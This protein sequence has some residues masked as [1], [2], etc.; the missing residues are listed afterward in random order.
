M[1]PPDPRVVR[2]LGDD[3]P[4]G[5]DKTDEPPIGLSAAQVRAALE[6]CA[7][8]RRKR[9]VGEVAEI[10]RTGYQAEGWPEPLG[11]DA[12]ALPDREGYLLLA[13]DGI[14]HTL[15]RDPFWAGYCSV[16]VNVNDICAMGGRPL[17]MVNVLIG[18]DEA[19]R[20]RIAEGI[21][22]GSRHFQVPMVGGH[23]HP[24]GEEGGVAVAILGRAG[25][26]IDSFSARPGDRVMF[27]VDLEGAW[28]EPFPHW[29]ST[30][31]RSSDEL[32][33]QL[34]VLPALGDRGLVRAGKD[35]SNPGFLGTLLMLMETSRTGALIEPDRLPHPP[36][37]DPIRWLRAY[38]GVAFVLAV[39]PD[40]VAEVARAW[41]AAGVT[42]CDVG[43]FAPGSSLVVRTRG[44]E[45]A[46]WDWKTE[47]VTGLGPR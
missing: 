38:P 15:L 20:R 24:D 7:G 13:A 35:V 22:F 34:E 46:V 1:R 29:D 17:A 9:A 32:R 10:L 18:A 30:R 8:L 44:E 40:A 5:L 33:R 31:R 2:C 27:A 37:V 28:H 42:A 14:W 47:P 12:A 21:A 41:E 45:V 26:L 3:R 4:L 36:G 43:C 11:D 6:D 39:P 25:H 23:L 16:L 19:R